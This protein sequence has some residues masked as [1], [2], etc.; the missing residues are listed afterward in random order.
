MDRQKNKKKQRIPRNDSL[1]TKSR[2][3]NDKIH[4]NSLNKIY[5][6]LTQKQGKKH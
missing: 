1:K 5:S 6:I 3:V 2:A 4:I